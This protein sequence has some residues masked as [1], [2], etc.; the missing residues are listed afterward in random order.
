MNGSIRRRGKNSW[1]IIFDLPRGADGKRKQARPQF[2]GPSGM[3]KRSGATC[4]PR[5][6]EAD[7]SRRRKRS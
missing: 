3:Q 4:S 6:T 5:W 7:T 2:T 1:Q